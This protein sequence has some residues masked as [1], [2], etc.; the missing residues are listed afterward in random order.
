M[1]YTNSESLECLAT[2]CYTNR[3]TAAMNLISRIKNFKKFSS[4][5]SFSFW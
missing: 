1:A 4:R 3:S 2:V 5:I